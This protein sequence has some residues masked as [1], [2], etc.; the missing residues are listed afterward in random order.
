M[1][2]IFKVWDQGFTYVPD[3]THPYF[4]IDTCT[5]TLHVLLFDLNIVLNIKQSK[6]NV[7]VTYFFLL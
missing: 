6:G 5:F 1:Y 4:D 3:M 7:I 2:F